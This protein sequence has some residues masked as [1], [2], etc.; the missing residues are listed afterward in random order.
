ME[1]YLSAA[2]AAGRR[3]LLSGAVPLSSRPVL[4]QHPNIRGSTFD[5][6][7]GSCRDPLLPA[8][9]G[10][11]RQHLGCRCPPPVSLQVNVDAEKRSSRH[12]PETQ[13]QIY[14]QV[15]SAHIDLLFVGGLNQSIISVLFPRTLLFFSS[16]CIPVKSKVCH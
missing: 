4:L 16:P 2:G 11:T 14:R 13:Q 15:L 12:N 6:P 9:A 3:G 7:V 1:P 8:R 10:G 5:S